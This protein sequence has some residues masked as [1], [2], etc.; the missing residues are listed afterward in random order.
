MLATT[1]VSLN[2]TTM[3]RPRGGG[4]PLP[5][6]SQR[7]INAEGKRPIIPISLSREAKKEEKKVE[8]L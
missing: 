5:G 3:K 8:P 4:H 6:Q 7:R 1:S 2:L